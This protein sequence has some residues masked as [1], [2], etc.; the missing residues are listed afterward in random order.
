MT[1]LDWPIGGQALDLRPREAVD[2]VVEEGQDQG[3]PRDQL[4]GLAVDGV[5]HA[6]VGLD[7]PLLGELVELGRA[8]RSCG[9]RRTRSAARRRGTCPSRDSRPS[10]ARRRCPCR[11]RRRASGTRPSSCWR[12]ECGTRSRETP[13]RARGR[14]RELSEEDRMDRGDELDGF[15]RHRRLDRAVGGGRG[16]RGRPAAGARPGRRVAEKARRDQAVGR[17]REAPERAAD[18]PVDVDRARQ[19]RRRSSTSWSGPRPRLKT[20]K[21]VVRRGLS[22]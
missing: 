12:G 18:E 5:A 13:P 17:D 21:Y 1:A 22:R 3:L 7:A 6:R 20:T 14:R 11:R 15:A 19:S 2:L 16:A 8:R 10:S 4:L 9:R